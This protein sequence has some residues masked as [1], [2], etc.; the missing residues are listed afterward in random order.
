[1]ARRRAT[2][3]TLENKKKSSKHGKPESKLK[4]HL[5]N[6]DPQT[7]K[8]PSVAST[9]PNVHSTASYEGIATNIPATPKTPSVSTITGTG[10]QFNAFCVDEIT[11]LESYRQ[12]M[13]FKLKDDI[14]RKLKFITNDAM[15]EFS[16]DQLSICQYVCHQMH[17]TG[18]QQGHFWTVVKNTIKRMIEK[19]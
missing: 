11:S 4:P 18:S 9:P 19:Q 13:Q 7:V 16:M 14:F 12:T 1:M 10:E 6:I 5:A 2:V 8:T 15:M 3:R 17:I